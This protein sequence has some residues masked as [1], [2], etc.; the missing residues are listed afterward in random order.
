[1]SKYTGCSEQCLAS[2]EHLNAR[3]LL[4]DIQQAEKEG[5]ETSSEAKPRKEKNDIF[6]SQVTV[7]F[8]LLV[9]LNIGMLFSISK[10]NQ[11]PTQGFKIH[12]ILFPHRQPK[13]KTIVVTALAPCHLRPKILFFY[14]QTADKSRI[15]IS[16]NLQLFISQRLW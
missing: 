2:S 14:I 4:F 16:K 7:I 10:D 5:R 11:N 3:L 13:K 12:I 1:M 9:T 15:S 6:Q 8:L